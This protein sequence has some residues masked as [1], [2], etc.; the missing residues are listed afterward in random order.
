MAQ[1]IDLPS[2][3][4]VV[5]VGGLIAGA[6]IVYKF[7][8]LGKD[9]KTGVSDALDFVG[10]KFSNFGNS[11]KTTMGPGLEITGS[12]VGK[13]GVPGADSGKAFWDIILGPPSSDAFN[14]PANALNK[15][16]ISFKPAP[17]DKNSVNST[18]FGLND[19]NSFNSIATSNPYDP[20]DPVN[21]FNK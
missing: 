8:S 5:T 15:G 17:V 13:Y 20:L 6:Y 16:L 2:V 19:Y 9:L 4:T 12:A 10:N 21:M 14:G 18:V 11:V 7:F 1:K 3:N